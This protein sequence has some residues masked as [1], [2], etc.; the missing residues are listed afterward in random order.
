MS[1][2]F[3]S[4]LMKRI[5]FTLFVIISIATISNTQRHQL[6]IGTPDAFYFDETP[7]KLHRLKSVPIPTHFAYS[8][9][10][11]NDYRI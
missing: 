1:I 10:L 9:T 5:Y 7:P 6:Q 8:F 2:L 4:Q 11:K 3:Q